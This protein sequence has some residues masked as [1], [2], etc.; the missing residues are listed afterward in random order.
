MMWFHD[1]TREAVWESHSDD[2][3]DGDSEV[4][5]VWLLCT[6]LGH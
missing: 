4:G 1:F 5:K 2:I 3:L 6:R